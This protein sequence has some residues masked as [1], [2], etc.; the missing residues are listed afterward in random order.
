MADGYKPAG[1]PTLY[2]IG[3]TTGS[4]SIMRVFPAWATYLGLNDAAIVGIDFPLH[5]EPARYREAVEFI[6]HDPLSRGALVTTHKIDLFEACHDLF[7]RLDPHAALMRE[8]SCISKSTE[9]LV[10]YAKDPVTAGLTLDGFLPPEHFTRTGAELFVIGAGGSA[11]AIT[12]HLMRKDRGGNVPRRVIVSDRLHERLSAIRAFHRKVETDAALEYV[13]A[14]PAGVNDATLARLS[15]GA[16]VVNATGLGKDAPGSPLTHAAQFPARGIVW[17]LN[18]RG[19][20]IFLNQAR[21]QQAARRLQIE[22]GW[23]YFIHGWTRIIAEVFG[24][25][26]PTRGPGFDEISRIAAEVGRP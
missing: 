1:R 25:D 14:T 13:D 23:T 11:T 21:A 2:F 15:P 3:V 12:W 9:G 16:L 4:S 10:A 7:D 19:D 22:N 24:I 5:A 20:L 17:E 26:I 8:T 18:Y 6:K